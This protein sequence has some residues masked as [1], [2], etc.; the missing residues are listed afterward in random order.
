MV[1]TSQPAL[2]CDPEKKYDD[3]ARIE[4]F[5][6]FSKSDRPPAIPMDPFF[7]LEKTT[8]ILTDTEPCYIGNSLLDSIGGTI[9]G[10]MVKVNVAKF[11]IKAEVDIYPAPCSLKIRL[12]SQGDQLA[13]E[14]QRRSGDAIAFQKTFQ[15]AS[16]LFQSLQSRA[17]G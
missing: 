14:F 3:A 4:T 16:A 11:A 2:L 6:R 8:V 1:M 12:Y 9:P 17:I 15:R 5:H 13:V 10:R 7:K